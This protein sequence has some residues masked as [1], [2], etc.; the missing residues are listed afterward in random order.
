LGS[1][2]LGIGATFH[3]GAT[4]Y[5]ANALLM[6]DMTVWPSSRAGRAVSEVLDLGRETIVP[7][8]SC[9]GVKGRFILYRPP[10]WSAGSAIWPCEG[11]CWRTIVNVVGTTGIISYYPRTVLLTYV[12]CTLINTSSSLGVGTGI[13]CRVLTSGPPVFS[14]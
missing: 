11:E 12:H 1:T 4:A 8:I 10:L 5:S 7:T 13:S 2:P 9:P 6:G 14:T 3:Q